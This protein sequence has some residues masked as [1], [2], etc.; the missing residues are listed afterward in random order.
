M[1][2]DPTGPDGAVQSTENNNLALTFDDGPNPTYTPQ[3]LALLGQYHITATFCLIGQNAQQYPELVKAI[4]AA[5][6]T[7]C[8]HSWDHDEQMADKSLAY[9]DN[10]LT[11]PIAAIQTAVPGASVHYYRQP[12]GNWSHTIVS[13]AMRM[14]MTPLDWSVDTDDWQRPGT[15][16]IEYTILNKAKPGSII[17]MHDGG[18]D[19]SQTIEALRTL[20]PTLV[21]NFHLQPM[22]TNPQATADR[23]GVHR[24][25]F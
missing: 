19:R 18:G 8:D 25:Y 22:P 20:L 1:P 23:S 24:P 6:N 2:T 15:A 13:E 12:G 21:A 10:E 17:L 9:I 16:S 5:G 11:R 14:G 4:V 7:L 3:V